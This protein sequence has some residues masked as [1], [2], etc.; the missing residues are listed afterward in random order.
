MEKLKDLVKEGDN[1]GTVKRVQE[2]LEQGLDPQVILNEGLIPS[3][4]EVGELFQSGEYFIPE[5]I[6]SARAM[7]EGVKIL[8]PKL[9]E[10]GVESLG[11]IIM[12]TVKGDRHDI[13]KNLV[14]MMLEGTF[15]VVD[16]G[17]DVPPEKFVESIKKHDPI[18]IGLSSLLTSTMVEMKNVLK[19]I[20]D[21]GL[22]DS[23]KILIG[24]APVTQQY[25]EEIGA[26]F[27]GSDPKAAKEFIMKSLSQSN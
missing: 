14:A 1:Q 18:A 16:L 5:L 21:A 19:E 17:V 23:L 4:D 2:L 7:K 15:E 9:V 22:R 6:I 27:Y 13:G 24:G 26:D 20:E 8:R 3:M 11:K 12:G 25:A 10:K